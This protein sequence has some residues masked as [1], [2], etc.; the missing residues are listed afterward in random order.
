MLQL[1]KVGWIFLS[2]VGCYPLS[3]KKKK[4]KP[5]NPCLISLLLIIFGSCTAK[6]KEEGQGQ[7]NSGCIIRVIP[8]T[9]HDYVCLCKKVNWGCLNPLWSYYQSSNQ[10][11][12][13]WNYL[14]KV[15]F[16]CFSICF[17]IFHSLKEKTALSIWSG[18]YHLFPSRSGGTAGER[19]PGKSKEGRKHQLFQEITCPCTFPHVQAS[20]LW[21]QA[22][23][24]EK[25]RKKD[26]A[27]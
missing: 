24:W 22:L 26:G 27:E 20:M 8:T 3:G 19:L 1:N 7:D 10:D 17:L 12:Q 23:W 13:L 9:A 25:V 2:T 4:V 15:L 16:V 21:M 18:L 5:P 14:G 6:G 11:Q